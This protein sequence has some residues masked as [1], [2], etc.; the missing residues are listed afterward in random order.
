MPQ[1]PGRRLDARARILLFTILLSGV[2]FTAHP[3]GLLLG[4]AAVLLGLRLARLPLSYAL[5]AL[6]SPL[7]F[8]IILAVLQ[9]LFNAQPDIGL[10]LLPQAAE[11]VAGLVRLQ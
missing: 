4:L 5:R 11:L 9:V 8:L 10:V 2:L 1:G 6:L 7:P 3:L